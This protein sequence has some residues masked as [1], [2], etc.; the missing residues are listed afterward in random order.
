ML[1]AISGEVPEV[2]VVST[3]TGHVFEKR[4]I[5][6]H[7]E[8]HDTCPIT[9][10]ELSVDDL[11]EV[12]SEPSVTKPRPPTLTSIPSLL[13][14]FQEEWDTLMLET[15]TLK[16]KYQQARQE[17][18]QA[19]Y[20]NDASCRVIARL[21][22]ERDAAR[23]ALTNIQQ[24]LNVT[25]PT[26][27]APQPVAQET[28]EH[29]A[30]GS[31]VQG[32]NGETPTTEA[33]PLRVSD[34]VRQVIDKTTKTLSKARKKRKAPE[35]L[36]TPDMLSQLK[37]VNTIPSLHSSTLPGI[38]CMA[39]N[40]QGSL[41][42]TGGEDKQ[43]QIYDIAKDQILT[44]LEGHTERIT[45]VAWIPEGNSDESPGIIVT[46]SDDRT[47][48]VWHAT[49]AQTLEYA[50]VNTLQIHK[51]TVVAVIVHPSNRYFV[52]VGADQTWVLHDSVTG[53]PLAITASPGTENGQPAEHKFTCAQF[54]PDG[55]ILGTGCSDGT[56][57]IWNVTAQAV[58][59]TLNP[60]A[61]PITAVAFSENGYYLATAGRDYTVRIWDLRK[62]TNIHT[63][64]L[65]P[66]SGT[67]PLTLTFDH[68]GSYLAVGGV[69]LRVYQVKVWKELAIFDDNLAPL[70]A[71][72]FGDPL[73]HSLITACMD[74]SLRFYRNP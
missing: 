27:A 20:Q 42:L 32:G 2:P 71:V 64:Q 45:S 24:H 23:E 25:A 43:V 30:R 29:E 48:R 19:L 9:G 70:T 53:K 51:S 49:E 54:H 21:L 31:P 12:K 37:N 8:Q 39:V 74:R 34:Q 5:L 36:S 15:F 55:A 60:G 1:C 18:A 38:T 14:V 65:D 33:E 50:C 22:K 52:S 46:S 67:P 73:A 17:L 63:I 26:T 72:H 13:S 6:K 7:L 61:E 59:A 40:P 41:L 62:Q 68:S 44:V 58:L 16:Q 57:Q 35:G 4:L 28:S 66:D 10:S 69:D 3:K 47:V 11:V 56:V